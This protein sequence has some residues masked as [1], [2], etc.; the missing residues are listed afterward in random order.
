MPIYTYRCKNCGDKFELLLRVG[1]DYSQ[2]R[3]PQCS[4]GDIEKLFASFKVF[5]GEKGSIL[6]K[7]S[8]C[9]MCSGGNC[10]TCGK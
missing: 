6:K 10:S 3:C 1:S 9:K 8:S 2:L 4:S 7:D 5:S